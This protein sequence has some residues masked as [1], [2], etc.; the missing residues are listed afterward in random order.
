MATHSSILTWKFHRQRRRLVGYS[1]WG[2]KESDMNEH[3]HVHTE[4]KGGKKKAKPSD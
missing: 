4:R 1:P 2:H 3:A